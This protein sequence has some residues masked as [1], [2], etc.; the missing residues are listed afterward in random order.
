MPRALA[1]AAASLRLTTLSCEAGSLPQTKMMFCAWGRPG[2]AADRLARSRPPKARAVIQVR[3]MGNPPVVL[4][5]RGGGSEGRQKVDGPAPRKD[6]RPGGTGLRGTLLLEDD[7][8][9]RRARR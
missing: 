5:A 3:F 8:D 7:G 6:C 1:L 9:V 2:G 4:C